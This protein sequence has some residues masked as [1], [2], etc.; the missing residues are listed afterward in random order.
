MSC[1]ILG[2]L[3]NLGNFYLVSLIYESISS[4]LV[5]S[6]WLTTLRLK[7]LTGSLSPMSFCS[8]LLT[9]FMLSP[10]PS[11][12]G[13]RWISTV[14]SRSIPGNNSYAGNDSTIHRTYLMCESPWYIP[15][16]SNGMCPQFSS[17]LASFP[18]CPWPFQQHSP[19]TRVGKSEWEEHRY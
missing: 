9:S 1:K 6:H 12:H 13:A 8:G 3:S 7:T 10:V 14:G 15:L 5:S 11:H 2:L 4:L 19:V 18:K 17:D 16:N